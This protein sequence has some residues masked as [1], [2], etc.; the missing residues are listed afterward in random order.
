MANQWLRLWHDMPT[1]P[2]WRTIARVSAQPIALVQAVYLHL[3]VDASR[4]VT[5]GHVTVTLE[6]LASALD[7][8]DEQISAVLAAMQ[9]R[10]IDGD[11]LTGWET[12]NPKR[13]DSGDAETGALSAAERKRN[14]R[15]RDRESRGIT[16]GHDGS[17]EVTPDKEEDKDKNPDQER[18]APGKPSRKTVSRFDPLTACPPNVTPDVWASWVQL[19]KEKRNPLTA[20]MCEHQAKQ[21]ADHINPDEVLRASIASGWTGLFPDKITSAPGNVLQHPTVNRH[22][23]FDQHNY[24]AGM[25]RREDGSYGF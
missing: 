24:A 4:N 22:N 12:R 23:D 7:V 21:L 5:R 1:D 18:G 17:R 13:E 9:G 20:T 15:Q 10:V 25:H 8:T 2:K 6:D 3:M 11:L 14:Q 16:S 19:R